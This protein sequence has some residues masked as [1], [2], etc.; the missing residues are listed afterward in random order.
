MQATGLSFYGLP[1]YSLFHYMFLQVRWLLKTLKV[2][3]LGTVSLVLLFGVNLIFSLL[4]T[5]LKPWM[6]KTVLRR[7]SGF[8]MTYSMTPL[9]ELQFD[10]GRMLTYVPYLMKAEDRLF[11]LRNKMRT[12]DEL[13]GSPRLPTDEIFI[14]HVILRSPLAFYT[15]NEANK[16]VVDL[17]AMNDIV[18]YDNTYYEVNG[19]EVQKGS[20]EITIFMK[21]ADATKAPTP[22]TRKKDGD[23]VFDRAMQSAMNTICYFVPGIGHSWVHFLFPDAV[24]ATVY[25]D[26]PRSS[27][28]YKLLEPHTRYTSRINWEAVGARGNLV[29]GGSALVR[30]AAEATTTAPRGSPGT[31]LTKKFEP[32]TA[33]SITSGEFVRKN[34]ERTTGYYFSEE[35]A[36]PPKWFQGASADL[37][38]IK[39][40]KR[41][42]PIVRNHV[43]KVLAFEDKS[44]I[45]RFIASVDNNSRID[46]NCLNIYRFDPIDVI[47]TLIFDAAFIHPTD[48]FFTYKNFHQTRYGVGTLRHPYTRDWYPGSRV[49]EDVMDPEDR[50][51]YAGFADV[52]VQFNDSKMFS[53]NMKSLKYTFKQKALKKAHLDFVNEIY[54]EQD[55]MTTE[56]DIFCPVEKLARSVCF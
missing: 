34:S 19:I 51:R 42:Y 2:R 23:A 47:A 56:G 29:I 21:S 41:F 39:S 43:A 30:L 18:H 54:K 26:V 7:F 35:F 22:V 8:M 37:P 28:L 36:C 17:S 15:T 10:F 53:N 50:V 12:A 38:Y 20:Q 48:H 44:T 55:K 5:I 1:N 16:L 13:I 11:S 33:M 3:V 25:N 40:L 27:V 52:F 31:F 24:A 32:V 49:P 4:F 46:D 9:A 6:N 14:S 45:D